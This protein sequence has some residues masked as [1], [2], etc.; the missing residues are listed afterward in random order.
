MHRMG[1][2][3][4]CDWKVGG[5][6]LNFAFRTT[7]L[8]LFGPG[9]R[10]RAVEHLLR[11]G[12]NL[13]LVT[14]AHAL[15]RAGRLQEL[16]SDLDR[17]GVRWVRWSVPN[18]PDVDLVDEGARLCVAE[19]CD[20]VLAVGGGSV[21]DA[22]K[23]VA[24]LATNGGS[25][26]EYLEDV[27]G[28]GLRQVTRPALPMVMLPTTAGTGSEVTRNAVIRVPASNVKRSMRGELL[29]PQVAIVDPELLGTAPLPVLAA[30]GMDALTH[31]TE[32]YLSRSA[33]PTTDA[34][35]LEGIRR[36]V[37]ALGAL[38]DG[39]VTPETYAAMALASLWGG[40]TL[41]NSG[42]GA[43]HG[44]VAPVGGLRPVPHGVGCARLLPE[45]LLVNAAAL[46]Q[47]DPENRALARISEVAT[48]IAGDASVEHA[49]D[50]LRALNQ[51]LEVPSFR[52][53]GVIPEDFSAI[54]AGSGGSSMRGNP[55][56]LT[57]SELGE[58]LLRTLDGATTC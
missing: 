33:N 5:P 52:A 30:A 46:G 44:L 39:R 16:T 41:A 42:L 56:T 29:Q 6:T 1:M 9:E 2:S 31:L 4:D 11:F 12:R 45:T 35:A 58:I 49:A 47:R 24:G 50:R 14:G 22:A 26:L 25:V 27:P 21:L 54:I 37:P 23:A 13:F 19:R 32:S 55:I 15:E 48:I 34:I 18:E 8:I 7:P 43:A 3:A 20:V 36:M 53:Y 17:A 10:A 57:E 38:A 51:R 28:G 40:I